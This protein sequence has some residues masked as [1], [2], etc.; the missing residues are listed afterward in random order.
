MAIKQLVGTHLIP[1]HAEFRFDPASA[2][3]A[4][5]DHILFVDADGNNKIYKG[6]GI[7]TDHIADEAVTLAKLAHAAANTVLV[8]DAGTTGDPSFKAVG[9]TELLI[10]DGTGFTAATLSGDVASLSNAGAVTMAAAQTNIQSILKDDMTDIGRAGSENDKI[11]F[12]SNTIDLKTNNI[13]RLQAKDTGV[14]ITGALAVSGNV[15]LQ[16]DLVVDGDTVEVVGENVQMKD[17]L[18]E[19]GMEDDGADGL[20]APTVDVSKDLGLVFHRGENG[21]S[22]SSISNLDKDDI[23]TSSLSSSSTSSIQFASSNGLAS[24]LKAGT[25]LKFTASAGYLVFR[26]DADLDATGGAK[27]VTHLASGY[28]TQASGSISASSITAIEKGSVTARV[29]AL[30]RDASD[31]GK[32]KLFSQVSQSSGVISTSGAAA[33]ALQVGALESAGIDN[34]GALSLLGS[35]GK[36]D[37]YAGSAPADGQLLIGGASAGVWQAATLTQGTGMKIT[38]GNGSVELAAATGSVSSKLLHCEFNASGVLQQIIRDSADGSASDLVAAGTSSNQF[39]DSADAHIGSAF[40]ADRDD[41]FLEFASNTLSLAKGD[42]IHVLQGSNGFEYICLGGVGSSSK[43]VD[44]QYVGDVGAGSSAAI[45]K[46]TSASAGNNGVIKKFAGS[47]LGGAA[48]TSGEAVITLSHV[49]WYGSGDAPGLE[50]RAEVD[51]LVPNAVSGSSGGGVCWEQ[52][53]AALQKKS[54]SLEIDMTGA[55]DSSV[56]GKTFVTMR[57]QVMKYFS[58]TGGASS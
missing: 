31:S 50:Y 42:I 15:V 33:A 32:F 53:S 16:G 9:D 40:S 5:A 10:G 30:F 48:V 6:Q 36:I 54:D 23:D 3:I 20:Q 56:T 38:N 12:G 4:A 13:S 29:D 28:G 51:R 35:S 8:R 7:L 34:T 57:V 19:L 47:T 44:V 39:N 17:T 45:T 25:V 37:T 52:D 58:T 1:K 21:T 49:N 18:M 41:T 46:A 26:L 55:G 14:D 2:T 24:T 22:F 11:S 43:R 27:A